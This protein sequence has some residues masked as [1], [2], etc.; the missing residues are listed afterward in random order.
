VNELRPARFKDFVGNKD[1]LSRLKISIK[2]ARSRKEPLKHVLL[3]GGAGLGKTSLAECIANELRL[4]IFI[5][6]GSVLETIPDVIQFVLQAKGPSVLFIDE[7]HAISPVVEEYLYPV[8]EDFK[9]EVNT[10]VSSTH[11]DIPF[12]T[13]IGATTN[14]GSLSQ[15]FRDRFP[16]RGHLDLYSE[17][18]LTILVQQNANLLNVVLEAGTAQF[19]AGVSKGTPRIANSRLYWIRDFAHSK[20]KDRITLELVLDAMK[21]AGID[22]LGLDDRDLKVLK[23]MQQK[24]GNKAVGLTS[25]A[26]ILG[27]S[28]TTLNDEIEPF[29]I[30]ANLLVRTPKGRQ[31]SDKGLNYAC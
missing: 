22:C 3:D 2:A 5:T 15:P 23:T 1:L 4:P 24:Y 7:T 13:F 31:L 28:T 20:G 9:L 17:K 21:K 12:V 30:Q 25:L 19:I 26:N 6:I 11:I 27:I 10:N 14:S 29:L 16:I 18:D 8:L